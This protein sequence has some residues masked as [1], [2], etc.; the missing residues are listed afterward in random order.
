MAGSFVPPDLSVM[1]QDLARKQQFADLLRQRAMQ[2]S[3]GTEM[4]GGWAIPKS[5]L[6]LV[7][8]VAQGYFG[9]KMQE[10]INKKNTEI[11]GKL[12]QYRTDQ[13]NKMAGLGG[14]SSAVNQGQGTSAPQPS[15]QVDG[16]V[17]PSAAENRKNSAMAQALAA[18]QDGNETLANDIIKN[19]TLMTDEEKNMAAKGQNPLQIGQYETGKARN[20]AT[21]VAKQGDLNILPDGTQVYNPKTDSGQVFNVN[22]GGIT[23]APG[24]SESNAGIKGAETTA[25]ERAKS[26]QE[27]VPVNNI[28]GSTSLVLRSSLVDRA[29]GGSPQPVQQSRLGEVAGTPQE[30][31]KKL[32]TIQDPSSREQAVSAWMDKYG[33]GQQPQPQQSSGGGIPVQSEGSKLYSL[34]RTKHYAGLS[35][36]YSDEYR[37]ALSNKSNIDRLSTLLDTSGLSSG[38]GAQTMSKLKSLASTFGIDVAGLPQEEA[39]KQITTEMFL[40]AKNQGGVNLL[41]GAMSE[42]DRQA[43]EQTTV[44]LSNSPEGRKLL[45]D[46][47]KKMNDRSIEVAKM[48]R[49]YERKHGQLDSGFEDELDKYSTANPM[50]KPEKT[51]SETAITQPVVTTGLPPANNYKNGTTATGDDGSKWMV[52]NG[53]WSQVGGKKTQ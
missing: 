16:A 5:P 45:L 50:F 17:P 37:S 11:A 39:I 51:A 14:G 21:F 12:M 52:V 10:D 26:K 3:Q 48:A 41:P 43:L 30:Q 35:N 25:I 20:D 31:L 15:A 34:E 18:Y 23:T 49:E 33:N 47:T 28:D 7:S 44:S 2:P 8:D 42:G 40:K 4:V 9:N 29:G 32:L 36:S 19:Y 6:S 46:R 38:S 53:K 1:Q 22:T 13:F 27:V 24:Y